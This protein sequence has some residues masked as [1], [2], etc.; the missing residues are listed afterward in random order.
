MPV[1][2][3]ED[4]VF[5]LWFVVAIRSESDITAE[6]HDLA[7]FWAGLWHR[8]LPSSSSIAPVRAPAAVHRIPT[9]GLSKNVAF[10]QCQSPDQAIR[11]ASGRRGSTHQLLSCRIIRRHPARGQWPNS[12]LFKE[13]ASKGSPGDDDQKSPPPRP[14][15]RDPIRTRTSVGLHG[16]RRTTRER[17]CLTSTEIIQI[18]VVPWSRTSLFHA[19]LLSYGRYDRRSAQ[20]RRPHLPAA[21]FG[22][23]GQSIRNAARQRGARTQ[24]LPRGGRR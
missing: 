23:Q 8:G 11:Q 24:S 13:D 14:G 22:L 18:P 9:C 4:L 20:E 6:I 17:H 15:R 10:L 5:S 21:D 12:G 3:L 19:A 16:R 1:E 7:R 2:N